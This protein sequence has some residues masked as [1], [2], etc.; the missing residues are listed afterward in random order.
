MCPTMPSIS[1]I[2][3]KVQQM[4]KFPKKVT[5]RFLAFCL[6]FRSH[7]FIRLERAAR[8][9][10]AHLY[11]CLKCAAVRAQQW[12]GLPQAHQGHRPAHHRL[13]V[14]DRH[15]VVSPATRLDHHRHLLRQCTLL[16]LTSCNSLSLSGLIRK[17]VH[18]RHFRSLVILAAVAGG[19]LCL[20]YR[21]VLQQHRRQPHR[22]PDLPD[23]PHAPLR[24]LVHSPLP[25]RRNIRGPV[26]PWA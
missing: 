7:D 19:G 12:Q 4:L 1:D 24:G 23:S 22:W 16:P 18:H 25:L 10:I 2:T 21:H 15:A 8:C 26:V 20:R 13:C 14:P 9:V 5:N 6:H 17:F 11:L 3:P